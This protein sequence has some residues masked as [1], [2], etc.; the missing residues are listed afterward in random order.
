MAAI[1]FNYSTWALRF[2]ALAANVPP[3]L[4]QM[5]FNEACQYCDNSA[6]SIVTDDNIGGQRSIYLN[7][8]TAHIATLNS[9]TLAQPA[10]GMVGRINSATEGTVTVQL[11]NDYAPG[12]QQWWQQTQPGSSYWAMSNQYRT[13]LYIAPPRRNFW[14]S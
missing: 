4:A 11:Q 14:P 13:A 6:T 8:I 12:T 7:L 10:N 1:V 5:Y 9:G 2:P 3:A